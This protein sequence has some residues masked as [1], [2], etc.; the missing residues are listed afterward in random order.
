MA[1]CIPKLQA[2]KL[3]NS[4]KGGGLEKLLDMTSAE[5][6]KFFAENVGEEMAKKVNGA[7]EKAIASKRRTAMIEFAKKVVGETSQGKKDVIDRLNKLN[8]DDLLN[9]NILE[10]Y[11]SETLGAKITQ[12]EVLTLKELGGKVNEAKKTESEAFQK[13]LETGVFTPEYEKSLVAYAKAIQEADVFLMGKSKTGWVETL[14]NHAKASMLFNPASWTVNIVSNLQMSVISR[15]ERKVSA[16]R[17]SGYN[18]EL[19]KQWKKIMVNV[20]KNTG[21]DMS[22]ALSMDEMLDKKVIGEHLP[23]GRDTWFTRFVYEKALGTNDAWSARMAFADSLDLHT[24]SIVDS[25]GLSG[26]AAKKK[27]ADI[28]IDAT[29]VVPLTPEGKQAR[30]VAVGDA[31]VATWTN[32]GAISSLTLKMKQLLNK[33]AEEDLGLKGFKVG[34]LLEPFVKT[35]AN[36]A[37]YGLDAA[38]VGIIRGAGKMASLMKNSSKLTDIQ[39][40]A[41]LGEAMRD[42]MRTGL[43][44][45]GAVVAASFIDED[46]FVGA[47][48]PNRYKY[49]QLR[50]SN[51][52]SIR[53]GDKWYSLDYLG[54]FATPLIGVLYAKKYGDENTAKMLAQYLVGVGDQTANIPF[55]GSLKDLAAGGLQKL[56]S[57]STPSDIG[58]VVYDWFSSQVTSR[59]PGIMINIAKLADN[60]ER[61]M[62]GLYEGIVGKIPGLRNS[63][64]PKQDFL[65][66]DVLTEKGLNKGNVTDSFIAAITQIM[67]GA[68]IKTAKQA[69]YAEEIV[70]LKDSGS[71]P[72]FT[73]WVYRIGARQQRLKDKVGDEK[74]RQI[75]REEYGKEV[76]KR[77]DSIIKTDS[78][79]KASDADKKKKIDAIN[80]EVVSSIYR[81]HGVPL[82][83]KK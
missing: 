59:V 70:R 37:A 22:R 24:A 2:T 33:F 48:D 72:S 31:Q 57:E 40:K 35:P 65:G 3:I 60:N 76:I 53:I 63:L 29:R 5:R 16:G 13:V 52:N 64:N 51:N 74:Y 11:V 41:L 68:R 42:M 10:D 26:D 80:D 20:R 83:D 79:K 44:V 62:N 36:I 9:E 46:D 6:R 1:L 81:R 78:Y 77:V 25:L 14:W 39:R 49:E 82:T 43:G 17:M 34:D 73:S 7:F 28:F 23:I 12:E 61:E 27:A 21:Y 69:P 38:G 58:K 32:K 71:A 56:D 19:A 30:M 50:N 55:V 4:L 45:G 8:D 18:P 66:Q 54:G 75:Y 67:A 15:M 47:Y